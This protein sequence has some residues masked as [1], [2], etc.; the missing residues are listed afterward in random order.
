MQELISVT[1]TGHGTPFPLELGARIQLRRYLEHALTRLHAD[2]D[3]AEVMRD[4]ETAIGDHLNAHQ[5]ITDGPISGEQMHVAP[6]EIGDI[7]ADERGRDGGAIAARGRFWCRIQEGSWS[8][9]SARAWRPREA[10]GSTGS[11]RLSR[12]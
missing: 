9:G 3:R 2:P 8:G 5:G 7:E 1:L 11:G 6:D 4:L 12:S 10:S